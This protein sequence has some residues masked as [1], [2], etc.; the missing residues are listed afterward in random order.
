MEIDL[1]NVDPAEEQE[2]HKLKR[3]VQGPD[4]YFMDVKCPVCQTVSTVFSHPKKVVLCPSCFNVL[5]VP[6]GGKGKLSVGT[7]WRRKG[8]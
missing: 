5:C 4:S 7:A 1:I 2:M 3:K 8:N 6:K